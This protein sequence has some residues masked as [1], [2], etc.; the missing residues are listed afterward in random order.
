MDIA[1]LD[2]IITQQSISFYG[3]CSVMQ[4]ILHAK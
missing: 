4:K 2:N 1:E 3:S